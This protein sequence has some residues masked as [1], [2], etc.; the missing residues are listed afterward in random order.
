MLFS[1]FLFL[2]FLS[3]FLSFFFLPLLPHPPPLSLSVLIQQ[4][5]FQDRV[6]ALDVF[7]N[8]I[9]AVTRAGLSLWPSLSGNDKPLEVVHSKNPGRAVVCS[10]SNV[11]FVTTTSKDLTE[12]LV[13]TFKLK[14]GKGKSSKGKGSKADV[15]E[16]KSV[17]LHMLKETMI[18][19]VR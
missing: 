18:D 15:S 12:V 7:D 3:V 2:F 11:F 9:I 8:N 13:L 4:D 5:Q 6:I 14:H 10:E 19:F 17:S 16:A 1:V